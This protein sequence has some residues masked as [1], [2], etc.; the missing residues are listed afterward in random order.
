MNQILKFRL[1]E[2][3]AHNRKNLQEQRPVELGEKLVSRGG[4]VVGEIRFAGRLAKADLPHQPIAF[5]GGQVRTDCVVRE[6]K[7]LCKLR[8]SSLCFA[9][10][11]QNSASRGLEE[12][13]MPITLSH[14]ASTPENRQNEYTVP[15]SEI[16]A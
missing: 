5:Q 1:A 16:V 12:S 7:N 10:Q 13:P 14:Y 6:L 2:L 3:I 15:E 9:K 8:D 11:P 4:E